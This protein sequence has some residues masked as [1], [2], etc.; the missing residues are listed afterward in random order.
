MAPGSAFCR[1]AEGRATAL[2]IHPKGEAPRNRVPGSLALGTDYWRGRYKIEPGKYGTV[3]DQFG[4]TIRFKT[5][6]A[7]EKAAAVEEE[8]A[9]TASRTVS[10][11][12]PER[13]TFGDYASR[14]YAAQDLAVSTMQNYRRHIEEHLL[15]R[16]EDAIVGEITKGEIDAW[17]RSDRDRGYAPS[18]I[19]TWRG[20]LHLI[21]ADAVDEELRESNPATRRRGRGKRAGRSRSRGPE[22]AVTSALGVLLIAQRAALLSGRDD[23]FVAVVLKGYTGMRWGEVVGLETKFVRPAAVRV[24]HQLYEL[25]SGVMHRCPP[26]DDSYRT[27]DTPDW[28]ARLLR[29]Q[30][31]RAGERECGCHGLRYLFSGHSAVNGAVQ[32][33][34]AKVVDVA[35]VAGVS[36][37]TVSNVLNRP[38]AVAEGTRAT[39]EKAIAD[40]GYSLAGRSCPRAGRHSEG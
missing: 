32:R 10:S 31:V 18:S 12:A 23:E 27:I 24:E 26:K 20:T 8:K 37:G 28:P 33:P 25:D 17:E 15:P 14:W 38:D 21:L 7:A 29:G 13:I 6:R 16:F 11:A 40:L 19:K 2:L 3:K 22:K 36:A 1:R 9:L 30:A 5:K 35:R 4:K 39:V 34:G